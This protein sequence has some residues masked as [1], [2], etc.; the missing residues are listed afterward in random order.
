MCYRAAGGFAFKPGQPPSRALIG[1]T[2]DHSVPKG[3]RRD[4]LKLRHQLLNPAPGENRC[5]YPPSTSFPC[6]AILLQVGTCHVPAAGTSFF[7][8]MRRPAC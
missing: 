7:P 1:R 5:K 4:N 8:T 6:S 2:A 3:Q